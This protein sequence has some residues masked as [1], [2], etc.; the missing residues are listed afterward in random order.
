MTYSQIFKEIYS[1]NKKFMRAYITF[2]LVIS[3]FAFGTGNLTFASQSYSTTEI[4]SI[5][6]GNGG[7]FVTALIQLFLQV[8]FRV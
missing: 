5:L 2:C 1:E 3:I 4:I 8:F 6:S 7:G